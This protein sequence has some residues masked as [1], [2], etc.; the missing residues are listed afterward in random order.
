MVESILSQSNCHYEWIGN[1]GNLERQI[2]ERNEK[3]AV[4]TVVQA[5]DEKS[6]KRRMMLLG[7]G[8]LLLVAIAVGVTVAVLTTKDSG[9]KRPCMGAL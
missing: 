9:S 1:A 3:L 5:T 4:A 8:I 6:S 2:Q 7:A